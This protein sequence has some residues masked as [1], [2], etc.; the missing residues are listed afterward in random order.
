MGI[1][2]SRRVHDIELAS[3]CSSCCL[4]FAADPMAEVHGGLE[5]TADSL[6]GVVS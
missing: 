3:P 2:G 1:Q 6:N 5:E 4:G